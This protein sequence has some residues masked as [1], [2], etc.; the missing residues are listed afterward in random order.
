MTVS[1]FIAALQLLTRLPTPPANGDA[2][3]DVASAAPW[4]PIIGV[5]VGSAIALAHWAGAMTSPW[6]AG[7]LGLLVWVTITGALHLDG[8]GDVSDALGAA[9]G[10]PERFMEVARDPHIGGFGAAAMAVQLIA[11]IIL[12]AEFTR[13]GNYAALIL[14]PAWARWQA[15]VV[16]RAAPPLS[17]GLGSQ[18]AQGTTIRTIAVY[19][20]LLAALSIW[21]M[22]IL[23]VAIGLALLFSLYW[24]RTVGGMTGDCLGATIELSE[25]ALLLLI[26]MGAT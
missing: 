21:V 7:L 3:R 14:I 15:L 20:A 11:K 6:L 12:L 9:H 18:L 4:L 23:C 25:T 10:N 8:L 5:V 17:D 2:S 22:P 16:A 19:A 26:V 24:R 13:T 1:G